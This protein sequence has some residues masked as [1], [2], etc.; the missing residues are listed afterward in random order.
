MIKQNKAK[1]GLVVSGL[2]KKYTGGVKALNGIDLSIESGMYGL[3]G[4]NGAGKSTLM[5]TLATLQKPDSG[6]MI[7]DGIDILA[8]PDRHRQILGYL[9]QQMGAYPGVSAYSLLRRFIWLKGFT[10]AKDQQ[11]EVARLLE[12][13]NLVDAAHRPV[14]T[15]S[16]GMLR[17]FGIAL[18]L[19]GSPRLIIVDEPTAGLDPQERNRFHRVLSE[20][21]S[22]SV[23]LLSTHI[24][25]DIENLCRELAIIKQGRIV[26]N[27][28]TTD[29]ISKWQ[30]QLWRKTIPRGNPIPKN[31]LHLSAC[32]DGTKVVMT[33]DTTPGEDFI[34]HQPT[35]EDVYY[36]ALCKE[37]QEKSQ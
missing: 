13:V 4:P 7:M 31:P 16:G 20:V 17:R 3:L 36:L 27:G 8:E 32:P 37:T 28:S 29:L 19:I 35:L 22:T 24:V 6:T 14:S 26:A 18:A 34:P 21:A 33:S 5:R 12:K 9:P 2:T 10:S 23:V 11:I 30:G 25:E 1:Q 15:Y